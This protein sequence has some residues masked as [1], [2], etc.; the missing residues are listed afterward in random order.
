MVHYAIDVIDYGFGVACR[1]ASS[2]RTYYTLYI[3]AL[4]DAMGIIAANVS[5][6]WR[7]PRSCILK[8]GVQHDDTPDPEHLCGMQ[9]LPG[10][11]VYIAHKGD[12]VKIPSEMFDLVYLV[13]ED[14]ACDEMIPETEIHVRAVGEFELA[15]PISDWSQDSSWVAT[16]DS[17]EDD[18]GSDNVN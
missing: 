5:G 6:S 15:V 10:T 12:K 4:Q 8:R 1:A 13:S 18:T 7:N 2:K 11:Q 17:S 3:T 14:D 9:D 16:D